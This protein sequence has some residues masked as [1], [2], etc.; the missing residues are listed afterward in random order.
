MRIQREPA[1]LLT[2]VATGVRFL[3]AFVF[4]LS[5]TQQGWIN[6]AAAAAAGL[7]VAVWVRREGQ[8][9]AIL[10]FVS[11]LLALGVAFGL[12]LDAE[13][14]AVIMSFVG[15]VVALFIR[16]QVVAPVPPNGPVVA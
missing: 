7:V 4:H 10:G 6:A 1:V 11:A 13:H 2:L 5:D 8:L 3:S 14:Q 12:H 16:T 15:G 9:P